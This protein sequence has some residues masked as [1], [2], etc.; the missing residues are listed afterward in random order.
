MYVPVRV[1]AKHYAVTTQTVSAWGERGSI[2]FVLTPGGQRRYLIPSIDP[3]ET[4][5]K[6]DRL[7]VCYCRVSSRG[8]RDDLERQIAYMRSRYPDH[9]IVQ[10][11]ASGIN[12][13]RPALK[14]LLEQCMS[15]N[16]EEVVVA[17]KDRLAR[18]GYELIELIMAHS[19]VRL[20]CL[21]SSSHRSEEHE[22]ADDLLA[23]VTV[24]GARVYGKRKYGKRKHGDPSTQ[25]HPQAVAGGVPEA[26]A[27]DGMLQADLQRSAS[28]DAEHQVPQEKLPVVEKPVRHRKKRREKEEVP[29]ADAQ[30]RA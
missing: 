25:G 7:R 26:E 19:G 20:L 14:A 5:E 13:R 12:W 17:H 4:K 30:A 23:I 1:A 11:V 24:F 6:K 29:V 22:L 21:D 15:G 2:R 9:H 18:F 16:V 3:G 10:D 8:Q 27:V 28:A